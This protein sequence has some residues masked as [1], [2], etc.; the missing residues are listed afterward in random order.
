M[1]LRKERNTF[2]Y[3][4]VRKILI[5][6]S[7]PNLLLKWSNRQRGR[8]RGVHT[9]SYIIK[10][11]TSKKKMSK[12]KID[13]L[14]YSLRK[15]KVDW[16][17]YIP[18]FVYLFSWYHGTIHTYIWMKYYT[19]RNYSYL[20]YLVDNEIVSKLDWPQCWVRIINVSHSHY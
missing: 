2:L 12:P 4:I 20:L 13:L 10:I 3:G 11:L 16:T 1:G 17:S 8:W 6:L 18:S 5:D 7:F 19:Q 14:W 9:Y 15:D